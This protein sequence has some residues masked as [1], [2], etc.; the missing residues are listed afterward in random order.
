MKLRESPSS[1]ENEALK[2]LLD[3]LIVRNMYYLALQIAK[4]LKL[5]ETVGSSYILLHW[6]KYKVSKVKVITNLYWLKCFILVKNVV[7]GQMTLRVARPF[8]FNTGR[9]RIKVLKLHKKLS[10][11]FSLRTRTSELIEVFYFNCK[12]VRHFP[13]FL[14]QF[15][16]VLF[17]KQTYSLTLTCMTTRV[18]N[19][20]KIWRNMFGLKIRRVQ[21]WPPIQGRAGYLKEGKPVE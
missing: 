11:N 5:P 2:N 21:P 10:N 8:I 14:P 18:E 16:R 12:T 4:Y 20:K 1:D 3:R 13:G 17:A 7:F 6:A 9:H 19:L 15:I